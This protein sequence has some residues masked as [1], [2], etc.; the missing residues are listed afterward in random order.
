MDPPS[1]VLNGH[2]FALWG[3]LD[4]ARA[5]GDESAWQLW[6]QGAATLGRHLPEYDCGYWSLYDLR[7]REL[8]SRYYQD[9]IHVPQLHAMHRLTDDA[10]FG[11][12]ARRWAAYSGSLLCRTRW[13]V[14]LR[15]RSR[16]RGATR[17]PR[18]SE[19]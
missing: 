2:V 4:W 6:R 14:G 5:T 18:S 15:L 3:V 13:A 8:A 12:Y 17:T 16:L 1:H 10:T 11:D 19:L 9:N 7:Y